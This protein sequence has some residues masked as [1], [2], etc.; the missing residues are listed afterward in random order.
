MLEEESLSFLTGARSVEAFVRF[1][2]GDAETDGFL[3]GKREVEATLE[4]LLVAGIVSRCRG[5]VCVRLSKLT[6][7]VDVDDPG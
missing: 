5:C 6:K 7:E 4:E 3:T 2:A 1:F